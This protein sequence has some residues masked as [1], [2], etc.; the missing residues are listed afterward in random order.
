MGGED[1][2]A[3]NIDIDLDGLGG[4]AQDAELVDPVAEAKAA[5]RFARLLWRDLTPEQ[6]YVYRTRGRL[7]P[8][9]IELADLRRD[10]LDILRHDLGREDDWPFASSSESDE[11]ALGGRAGVQGDWS[12][13]ALTW[14]PSTH[15]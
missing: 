12:A 11:E 7:V 14:V 6:R 8:E 15:Q 2:G 10:D 9:W 1:L 13:G 5:R 3:A 4:L